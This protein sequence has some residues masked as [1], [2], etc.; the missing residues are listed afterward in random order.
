MAAEEK[1]NT[2]PRR[3][4]RSKRVS[5]FLHICHLIHSIFISILIACCP[6]SGGGRCDLLFIRLFLVSNSVVVVVE[7]SR[8]PLSDARFK[9]QRGRSVASVFSRVNF[10]YSFLLLLSEHPPT[11]SITRQVALVMSG[12][13]IFLSL[14]HVVDFWEIYSR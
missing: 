5:L 14:L 2:R 11:A 7:L 3:R 12:V 8:G 6:G 4:R 1:T 10:V 9:T 13:R